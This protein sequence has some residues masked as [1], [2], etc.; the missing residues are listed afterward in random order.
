M[1]KAIWKVAA[2]VGGIAVV[3]ILSSLGGGIPTDG[4]PH[5]LSGKRVPRPRTYAPTGRPSGYGPRTYT[6]PKWYS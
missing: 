4:Y 2:V 5:K 1:L 3:I 6:G